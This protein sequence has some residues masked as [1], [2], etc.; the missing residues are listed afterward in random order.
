MRF[1]HDGHAIR[2]SVSEAYGQPACGTA[3]RAVKI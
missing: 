3:T 1:R 2:Y